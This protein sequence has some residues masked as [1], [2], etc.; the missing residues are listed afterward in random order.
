M[1]RYLF[2]YHKISFKIAFIFKDRKGHSV[3]N[4]NKNKWFKFNDTTVEEIN[5]TDETLETECFGGKFK[6]F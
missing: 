2:L 3:V 4:M 5:M 6:V 1:P